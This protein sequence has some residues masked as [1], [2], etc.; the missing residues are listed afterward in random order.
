M[1]NTVSPNM[2]LVIPSVGLEPGPDYAIDVNNSLSIIDLHDHTSGRGVQ[3]TP[4]GL[5]LDSDVSFLGNN[6]TNLRSVRFNSQGSPLALG[7]DKGCL[8]ESGVDLYY[9][10]GNGNQIRMTSGGSVVGPTGTI[11]GLVSPASATYNAGT[12]TFIWQSNTNVA[13]N[14]DNASVTIRIPNTVGSAGTTIAASLSLVTPYTITL[15][16]A[17][18][19][20][21]SL[22][23]MD[24][25]GNLGTT[26]TPTIDSLSV[27]GNIHAATMD[28]SGSI[29][30]GTS[31]AVI[32]N[33][34]TR[35]LLANGVQ[36]GSS[37]GP[38]LDDD[39]SHNLRVNNGILVGT[40]GA[41]IQNNA[42]SLQVPSLLIHNGAGDATLTNPS[43]ILVVNTG[44][45]PQGSSN[46]GIGANADKT[47]YSFDHTGSTIGTIPTVVSTNT[48]MYWGIVSSSGTLTLGSGG[49]TTSQTGTGAYHIAFSTAFSST[50]AAVAM[51][52]SSSIVGSEA[53]TSTTSVDF[54][55]VNFSST[56]TNTGFHFMV[57]GAL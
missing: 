3:I 51:P 52:T 48:R 29:T 49:F 37:A 57:M 25:S 1:P 14:M 23:T 24:N 36:L 27:T 21:L 9:N 53:G 43:G 5:N 15:P 46:A 11:T 54:N 18:P 42:G 56:A 17:P 8:Y 2:S 34:G 41:L 39:G 7:S 31:G 28:T 12:Q 22:V 13:A 16:T 4:A 32:T 44:I 40:G 30:V 10:D 38:I 55:F 50:P 20:S 35:L 6:A 26:R 19:A 33:N 47:L 45:Q